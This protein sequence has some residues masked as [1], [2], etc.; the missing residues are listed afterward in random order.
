MIK[1]FRN[2]NP[3][4]IILLVVIALVLRFGIL[5][6]LP[7]KLHVEFFEPFAKLLITTPLHDIFSPL[8]NVLLNVAIVLVQALIFNWVVNHHNL[9]GKPTYLPAL[10]YV[11]GSSMLLPFL[12]LSPALICNFL[13][14][15]IIYKLLGIYKHGAVLSV[16]YDTGMIIGIGTIIYFPFIAFSLALWLCLLVFRPFNWREWVA[17]IVGFMTVFFFIA[18]FYYWNDSLDK[19]YQIWLPLTTPFPTRFNIDIYNYLVLVPV[20]MILILAAIQLRQKFFRSFVQV[21]KSFQLLF[22]VLIVALLSF[23]LKTDHPIYHFVLAVPMGAVF[24]A[25]Y[26]LNASIRWFYEGLYLLLLGAIIYFQ[27]SAFNLF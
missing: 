8:Q 10:L 24:M 11:T 23:Y 7:E 27:L 5:I 19:F 17:G 22:L 20:I 21:R 15:W 1:L 6:S 4:N 26:F 12:I 14:I 3:L 13:L 2:L 16:M 9:L 25:Y 18:V